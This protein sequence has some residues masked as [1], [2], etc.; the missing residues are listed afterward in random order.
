MSLFSRFCGTKETTNVG[1]N[2]KQINVLPCFAP[3]LQ[4]SCHIHPVF[5]LTPFELIEGSTT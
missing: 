5:T 1:D 3:D 2:L 4:I